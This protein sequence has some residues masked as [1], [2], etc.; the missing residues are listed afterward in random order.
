MV[1]I[2][3]GGTVVINLFTWMDPPRRHQV[4]AVVLDP[5][6]VVDRRVVLLRADLRSVVDHRVVRL[7]V[8]LP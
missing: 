8:D 4:I 1:F 6:W 3:D 2:I 5:F 7:R